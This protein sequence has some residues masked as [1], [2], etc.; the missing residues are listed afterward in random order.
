MV[1]GLIS[2]MRSI[3]KIRGLGDSR[4]LKRIVNTVII[5]GICHA[6]GRRIFLA[7]DRAHF[8]EPFNSMTHT[9]DDNSCYSETVRMRH[10]LL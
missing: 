2:T 5:C 7:N 8:M 6:L 1:I 4:L 10:D 9:K 3:K